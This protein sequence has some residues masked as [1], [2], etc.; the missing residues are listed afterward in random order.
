MATTKT[1]QDSLDRIEE[2]LAALCNEVSAIR[3]RVE[4]LDGGNAPMSTAEIIE[5]FD[6]Y[7]AAEAMAESAFGAWIATSPTACL[8]GGLRAVQMRE[9][10]HAR[11]FEQ[12]IKELG[13]S[14]EAEMPP[15]AEEFFMGTLANTEMTDAQKVE[16][17][18]AQ[19]GDPK[20][21][22]QLEAA[23]ARMCNDEESQFLLRSVIE[24]EKASLALLCQAQ[25]LLCN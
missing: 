1:A 10:Y 19:A 4:A 16:S 24:D 13:G 6:G 2:T 12:R 20:V 14:C 21:I 7:R 11:L 18:M 22:E 15:E 23:A 17:F 8:R 5:F 9:G 3:T 25:E